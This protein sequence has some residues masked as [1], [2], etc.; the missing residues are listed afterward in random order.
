LPNNGPGRH[1][2]NGDFFLSMV[3]A[4]LDL[5]ANM[6]GTRSVKLAR[7][8]ADFSQQE[9]SVA[10]AIDANDN[11]GWAIHPELGKPHFAVLE[12][13]EPVTDTAGVVLRVTFEF[14]SD[15]K[16]HGLG[17]FR[18]SVSGD[19]ATFDQEEKRLAVSKL[20]D[21]WV[22]L[23]AAYGLNGRND[24]ATEYFAK[25]LQADPKLGDDRQAQ[26]RYHAA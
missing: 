11:T 6:G 24:K 21:P 7:A 3:K 15:F 13:A 19:P 14:K 9:H 1:G 8:F 16:Q 23:A 17:R 26:H 10:G 25:A 4:Q 5:P 22:K 2:P 12:L 18:L 20:T